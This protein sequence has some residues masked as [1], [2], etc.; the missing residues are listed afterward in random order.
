MREEGKDLTM[1]MDVDSLTKL[2]EMESVSRK[3]KFWFRGMFV[4][5]GV[6]VLLPVGVGIGSYVAYRAAAISALGSSPSKGLSE[7]I[8]SFIVRIGIGAGIGIFGLGLVL[9][10]LVNF[11]RTRREL[12]RLGGISPS[13]D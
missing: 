7:A 9:A 12:D 11:L 13:G 5:L 10:C 2:L 8:D 4:S 1:G 6:A 3:M